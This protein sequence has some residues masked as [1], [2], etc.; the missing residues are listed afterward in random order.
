MPNNKETIK[1]QSSNKRVIFYMVCIV[2][3]IFLMLPLIFQDK[4][5]SLQEKPPQQQALPLK[6]ENPFTHYFNLFKN[7]YT[8]KNKKGQNR[9]SKINNA[10]EA[11]NTADKTKKEQALAPNAANFSGE[12]TPSAQNNY[13]E[14]T[15][16]L[17]YT[18][19][20]KYPKTYDPS[21]EGDN[22]FVIQE[23]FEDFLMEG[24]YETSQLDPYEA[25]QTARKNIFDIFSAGP[26]ALLPADRQ[27]EQSLTKAPLLAKTNLPQETKT[28]LFNDGTK[29]NMVSASAG[30]YISSVLNPFSKNNN[31][32]EGINI[33]GLP[34]ETQ[35]DLVASR[36]NTIN[37]NNHSS[38][39]NKPNTSGQNDQ[40]V[41]PPFPP[42]PPKDTFD[43]TKWDPQ[44]DVACSVPSQESV[45]EDTAQPKDA[46][47]ENQGKQPEKIEHCDQ[48][49][50]DKLPKVNNNM[51]KDYNYLLVSG[52]Y[53]GKI[54][55]PAFNSLSDTILT[56]GI[57]SVSQDF[58]NYPKQL[59]GKQFSKN[60]KPTN[61][62]FVVDLD[63]KIFNQMMQEEKTIL[64]SVDP[65]D[66]K[67]YPEK[68]ILIQSGEIET[69]P[70]VFRI[71]DEINNFPQ[72]QAELKKAAQ[73]K[74]AQENQQKAQDLQNKI[75]AAI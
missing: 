11:K 9:F 71:I 42:K 67:R 36:L 64:L 50:Q 35:A 30:N 2:V 68:T 58:L 17:E 5:S 54:M 75:N 70:G 63:P 24:L 74:E 59:Q 12:Q 15:G 28:I 16:S 49:L 47:Q 3:F 4:N 34:F 62:K 43:P 23:P 41:K 40:P 29:T 18:E 32:T 27:T 61:F 65:E 66:Q 56:F 8:P 10:L 38:Y 51:Q 33:D 25:K 45:R 39:D 52:R 55:I 22:Y 73:E 20:E 21:Q 48:D 53:K 19:Q 44:V 1:K 6:T 46:Q 14:E 7:F 60:T 37:S 69:F 13:Y 72:K 26:L 57:Q 31:I